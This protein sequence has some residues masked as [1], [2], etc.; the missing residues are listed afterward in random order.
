MARDG[1][2]RPSK[3]TEE[4]G[5]FVRK[6]Y[7]QLR[8]KG[9]RS[10][11]P[12]IEQKV[13]EKLGIEISQELIRQITIPLREE[14]NLSR[15]PKE[16]LRELLPLLS[17]RA[18]PAKINTGANGIVLLRKL[19]VGFYSRYAGE[20]LLNVYLARLTEGVLEGYKE[21][22][23]TYDIRTFMIMI[24]PM[25][26]FDIVNYRKGKKNL[27]PGIWAALGVGSSLSLKTIRRKL[28]QAVEQI[29]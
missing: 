20:L 28:I 8:K 1:R 16:T 14:Q 19:E 24:I 11:R 13:K 7:E 12:N 29:A 26:Q 27:S 25:V 22:Q 3:V 23:T 4:I 15:K 21:Q 9:K 6:Q 17:A 5:I 18:L 2:G 10:F